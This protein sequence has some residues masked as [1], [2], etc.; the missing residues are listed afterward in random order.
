MGAHD[1]GGEIIGAATLGLSVSVGVRGLGGTGSILGVEERIRSDVAV[2]DG[3]FNGAIGPCKASPWGR[4]TA[5]S[6]GMDE[7]P[8]RGF[9]ARSKRPLSTGSSAIV[10]DV[11]RTL[12][13]GA[14]KNET[15]AVS[16]N[17][18]LMQFTKYQ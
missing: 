4:M 8:R 2:A 15:S 6:E 7:V 12:G 3:H 11:L 13:H 14:S 16:R 5:A 9:G 17:T 1:G 18:R 10:D